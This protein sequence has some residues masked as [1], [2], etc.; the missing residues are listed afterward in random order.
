MNFL[1]TRPSQGWG[2]EGPQ[3][4]YNPFGYGEWGWGFGPSQ[5]QYK[6]VQAELEK[7]EATWAEIE[8][9]RAERMA[10]ARADMEAEQALAWDEFTVALG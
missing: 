4:G 7:M 10:A 1:E 3:D 6:D 8:R 2:A 5:Q 9:R